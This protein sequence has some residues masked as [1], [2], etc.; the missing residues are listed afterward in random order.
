MFTKKRFFILII[1]GFFFSIFIGC[2]FF[3]APE[4]SVELLDVYTRDEE[5]YVE[6]YYTF[7]DSTSEKRVSKTEEVL[8]SYLCTTVKITNTCDKNIYNTTINIQANAGTRTYYK[9]IS[10]DV[11]ITPGSSI[12]I[13]VEIEKYTKQLT[14]V[15]KDNDD[16]WDTNSI[17][18]ISVSWK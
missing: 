16:K 8:I 6:E 15:N 17:K 12:Y 10:L 5:G 13:P 7:G 3:E 18:I 2:S 11:T 14:A 9:T 4:G 1:L